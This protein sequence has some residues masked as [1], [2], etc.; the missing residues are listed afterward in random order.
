MIEWLFAVFLETLY[1]VTSNIFSIPYRYDGDVIELVFGL[2]VTSFTTVLIER[3]AF[4]A[5][6]GLTGSYAKAFDLDS[7]QMK[8]IHWYLRLLFLG[9]A[10]LL[11]LTP[12]FSIM[13]D[14]I[15]RWISE[16]YKGYLND[17]T[18][19]FLNVLNLGG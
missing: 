8:I 16:S 3:V 5:S 14:P 1:F 7:I 11:T 17:L 2:V 10:W 18:N 13:L 4:L 15:I 9:L 12:I 6:F 19:V